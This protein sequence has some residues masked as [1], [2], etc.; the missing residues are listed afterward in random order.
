MA[1]LWMGPVE[2][3][4]GKA[5]DVL[6]SEASDTDCNPILTLAKPDFHLKDVS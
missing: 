1:Q 2:K 5:K 6:Q 3:L 4:L